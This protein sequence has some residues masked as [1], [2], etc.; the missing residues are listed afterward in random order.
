MLLRCFYKRHIVKSLIFT[1][2]TYSSVHTAS[3][4]T[5]CE[6]LHHRLQHPKWYQELRIVDARCNVSECDYFALHMDNRIEGSKFFSFDECRDKNSPFPVML[7]TSNAFSTYVSNLGI[8]NQH[9]VVVYDDDAMLGAFF[10]PRVW[11]MFRAFGHDKVSILDGGFGK[12]LSDGYPSVSG[13]YTPDEDLPS[14]Q[15][16]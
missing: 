14:K 10:S 11:W 1:A 3:A 12:W 8:S 2:R 15:K 9:H 7:P 5:S 6:E 16:F 13:S 4:L